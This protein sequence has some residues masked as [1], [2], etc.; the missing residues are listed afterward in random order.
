MKIII[1]T[2]NSPNQIA[3]CN[4]IAGIAKIETII[5]SALQSNQVLQKNL[6]K[7]WGTLS[8]KIIQRMVSWPLINAWK[9]M[10]NKYLQLYPTYPK[11]FL[12]YV[13]Q[14]NSTTTLQVIENIKPD[15]VVVSG[16]ELIKQNLIECTTQCTQGIINLHTGLS[17]YMNG[18]PNCT[19]WCLASN[20][21]HLIGN[22][23]MYL[24]KGIDSGDIITTGKPSLTGDES[25]FELHWKV[26]EHAHEIY[27]NVIK[28]LQAKPHLRAIPQHE[29]SIGR[30][31]YTKEW[32]AKNALAAQLNFY[33]H[34]TPE[35]FNSKDYQK[36]L[37]SV[38][39]VS[40]E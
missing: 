33:Q 37:A 17:P 29:I 40:L 34:F 36:K 22:T 5:I 12:K 23:V 6:Q 3:L 16:T 38:K 9:K 4:K 8:N 25:L 35:F 27:L 30:T 20:A 26:M 31:F 19:N 1:L 21:F 18:G 39:L 13:L 24:D 10:Q 28:A 32:T 2:S 14:I 15:L 7:K 11:S